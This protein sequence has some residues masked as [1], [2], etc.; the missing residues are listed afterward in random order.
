MLTSS[1]RSLEAAKDTNAHA[2][3]AH[4]HRP[5]WPRCSS[6][7]S[8]PSYFC[9]KPE[10][11]TRWADSVN[12]PPQAEASNT[13]VAAADHVLT[14]N[15]ALSRREQISLLD[16]A[17]LLPSTLR[18]RLSRSTDDSATAQNR[19]VSTRT[20]LMKTCALWLISRSIHKRR[21]Q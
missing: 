19:I 5:R 1:R 14:G 12:L 18:R 21:Q 15:P 16:C 9:L 2:Q 6:K 10:C 17:S 11:Q 13:G 7:K 3:H 8:P 20:P 4:A